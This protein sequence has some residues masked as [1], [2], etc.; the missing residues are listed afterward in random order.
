MDEGQSARQMFN[1]HSLFI[2]YLLFDGM[3]LTN[4]CQQDETKQ[5][6]I[7]DFWATMEESQTDGRLRDVF[8]QTS[9]VSN[10]EFSV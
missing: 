9:P 10:T 2:L 1:V 7:K 4:T 6:E 3:Y 8:L 5:E